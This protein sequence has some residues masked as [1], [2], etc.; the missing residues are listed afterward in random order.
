MS[1]RIF[2]EGGG[3]SSQLRSR[4]RDGFRRLFEKCGFS[5][6]MP[7]LVASGPRQAAFEDFETAHTDPNNSEFVVMLIDSEDPIADIE[8]TWDHLRQRDGWAKPAN[9][10]DEQVLFMTTCMETWIAADRNALKEAYARRGMNENGLPP[11]EALESRSRQ[12]VFNRLK[13]GTNN[14]FDKGEE[15]FRV[16]GNLNPGTIEPLLPS[17]ARA[18]R[19]LNEKL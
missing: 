19:I 18:R 4:C 11:Q 10:D 15:S 2:V 9:A 14:Q 6:R 5:G 12:D 13:N 16:L 7:R 1:A 8:R 3:D 17:F